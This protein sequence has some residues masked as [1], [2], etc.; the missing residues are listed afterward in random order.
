MFE[1]R[2]F[3]LVLPPFGVDTAAVYR[4]YDEAGTADSR[5]AALTPPSGVDRGGRA[6]VDAVSDGGNDLE[7]AALSV[8]PDLVRWR[9]AL[10]NVTGR[11]PRLAGSGSTWFVE[12][13]LD[14]LNLADRPYLVVRGWRAPVVAVRSVPEGWE[15]PG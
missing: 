1:S 12:G 5:T 14:D 11:R 4:A 8:A 2:S 9:D 13:S 3:A 15:G 6:W 7:A 10:G